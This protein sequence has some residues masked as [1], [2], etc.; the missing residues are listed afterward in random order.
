MKI[1]TTLTLFTVLFASV[2]FGQEI[3]QVKSVIKEQ[4]ELQKSVKAGSITL[5]FDIHIDAERLASSAEYYTKYFTVKYDSETGKA[6]ITFVDK[7]KESIQILNRFFVANEIDEVIF[8]AEILSAE[9]FVSK[10]M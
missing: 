1:L 2:S 8:G 7:S 9:Q 3:N 4:T 5:F 10:C 6:I